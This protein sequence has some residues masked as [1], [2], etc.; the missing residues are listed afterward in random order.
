MVQIKV[1]QKVP[2]PNWTYWIKFEVAGAPHGM[3]PTQ[4][5]SVHGGFDT[6]EEARDM[7]LK[8]CDDLNLPEPFEITFEEK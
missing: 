8:V 3:A 4:N 7:A 6:K 5:Y 2:I 1:F